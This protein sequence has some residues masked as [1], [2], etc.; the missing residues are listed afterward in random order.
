LGLGR[1]IAGSI[2]STDGA[3]R[4]IRALPDAK[5]GLVEKSI[6]YLHSH[7]LLN[8]QFFIATRNILNLTPQ[9]EAVLAQYLRAGKKIYLLLVRY[10]NAKEA[11]AALQG[12]R[13]A[14]MPEASEK[15]R[16]QTEDRQWTSTKRVNEFVLIVFGAQTEQEAGELIEET[17]KKI[18]GI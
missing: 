5:L 15:G 11:A 12:F 17:T 6:R 9:T 14:Y 7:I 16:L 8:Q 1:A 3:P 10:A 13:G 18:G 4:L 2:P